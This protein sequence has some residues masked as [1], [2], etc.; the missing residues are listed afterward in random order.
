MTGIMGAQTD[1]EWML[2]NR[3]SVKVISQLSDLP[4]TDRANRCKDAFAAILRTHDEAARRALRHA[5][6][7]SAP[8]NTQSMLAT[9]LGL[10][11]LMFV[12][13]NEGMAEVLSNQFAQLDH[14]SAEIERLLTEGGSTYPPALAS[15]V[16]HYAMPDN[17]CQVNVLQMLHS[18]AGGDTERLRQMGEL[19]AKMKMTKQEIPIVPWD[20][21][22]T[23]FDTLH[24]RTR[25]SQMD[26]S[27]G[28]QTYTF[29]EWNPG[30]GSLHKPMRRSNL[31][32]KSGNWLSDR[33]TSL[34]FNAE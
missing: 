26:T 31:C 4:Q 30:D 2:S 32:S 1:L 29:Y 21:R 12:A 17:R 14:H 3:R 34:P 27:K 7:S 33:Q 19:C 13:A 16:R 28:V 11:A 25:G 20:A 23:W 9:K 10:C 5:L 6:D 22:I 24:P 8:T 15:V 18:G